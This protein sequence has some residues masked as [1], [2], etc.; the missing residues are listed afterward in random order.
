MEKNLVVNVCYS[1][2]LFLQ[3]QQIFSLFVALLPPGLPF[4]SKARR[5]GD[6]TQRKGNSQL[7]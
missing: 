3:H 2:F 6:L 5:W 4:H 7:L 1:A